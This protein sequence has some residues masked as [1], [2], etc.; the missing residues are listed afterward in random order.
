MVE[1]EAVVVVEK[2]AE[3]IV[4][5]KAEVVV[6][7]EITVVEKEVAVVVEKEA[8]AVEKEVVEEKE[9]VVTKDVTTEVEAEICAV[10]LDQHDHD[11]EKKAQIEKVSKQIH[12]EL[13]IF[14]EE[15][16]ADLKT[17]IS[18]EIDAQWD[19]HLTEFDKKYQAN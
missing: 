5:E 1:K 7:K 15:L 18:S 17:A 6:E 14:K 10:D 3:V 4:E 16:L 9:V 12:A 11:A 19:Y 13:S 2:E 8:T